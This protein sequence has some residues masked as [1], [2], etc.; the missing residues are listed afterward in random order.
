M[1]RFLLMIV[2]CDFI[3]HA[4]CVMEKLCTIVTI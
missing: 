3:A 2:E 1:V 4:V